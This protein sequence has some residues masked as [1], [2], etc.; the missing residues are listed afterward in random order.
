MTELAARREMPRLTLHLD[1]L[2]RLDLTGASALRAVRD[3]AERSGVGWSVVGVTP[4]DERLVGNLISCSHSITDGGDLRATVMSEFPRVWVHQGPKGF[5][6]AIHRLTQALTCIVKYTVIQDRRSSFARR[7]PHS[8][9]RY[10]G[11]SKHDLPPDHP[12]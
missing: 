8:A 1:A 4:R 7:A 3:E 5:W 10:P 9:R 12:R 6:A 11:G 2:G